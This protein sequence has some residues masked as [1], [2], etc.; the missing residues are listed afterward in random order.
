MEFCVYIKFG[1]ANLN[2]DRNWRIGTLTVR[3]LNVSGNLKDKGDIR[4]TWNSGV[5]T[6]FGMAILKMY[7]NWRI[8]TLTVRSLNVYKNWTDEGDT[9]LNMEFGVYT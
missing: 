5:Y 7:R 6:K 4:L 1:M 8:D 2:M 3:S 9:R